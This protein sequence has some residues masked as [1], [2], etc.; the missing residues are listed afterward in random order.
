MVVELQHIAHVLL[1]RGGERGG[2]GYRS[3]DQRQ[4]GE[5]HAAALGEKG[6]QCLDAP[7][8]GGSEGAEKGTLSIM[9]GGAA[10][11]VA[12]AMPVFETIGR[13][14]THVGGTGAGQTVKLVNQILV[15]VNMLAV[16]EA[17]VFAEAHT[18]LAA[19]PGSS[20]TR[21]KTMTETM[22]EKILTVSP[23]SRGRSSTSKKS[24]MGRKRTTS[25]R[26]VIGHL[27]RH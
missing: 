13:A 23:I 16:G 24:P 27:P 22:V 25:R 20:W 6:V 4:P 8:S 2:R 26:V 9:V 5:L 21:L 3:I 18:V 15:V 17:L 11:D 12:R 14:V 10:E 7:V 19:S 1:T